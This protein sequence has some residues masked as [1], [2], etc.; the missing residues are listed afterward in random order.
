MT[1]S[2]TTTHA[3]EID[4]KLRRIR[5]HL[6]A[7]DRDGLLLTTQVNVSWVLG[8]IDHLVSRTLERSFAWVL[9][10]AG[11]FEV[12]ALENEQARLEEELRVEALG[13][14]LI[15]AP[16]WGSLDTLAASR[17]GTAHVLNDGHG[18]GEAQPQVAQR[19]RLVLTEAERERMAELGAD[20]CAAVEG[21]LLDLP[22]NFETLTERE[23]AARV[24]S[25]FESRG[26]L[27]SGVM[28]G[29]NQR[30]QRYRHPV[31]T[32]APLGRDAMVVV[33][34]ARGGLHAAL[35]RT[36]SAV[37]VGPELAARHQVACEVEATMVAGSCPGRTWTEAL[38]DGLRRYRDAG[39]P[40]EWRA[41][42]QGG[43]IGYGPREYVAYP[44]DAEIAVPEPRVQ[45]FQ[46]FAWN[47]T[48]KGTKSEDT[49]I[50]EGDIATSV[51]NS[52]A[53][54]AITVETPAG[55]LTRPA[56]LEL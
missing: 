1:I 43:P 45:S 17:V 40:D 47:P 25:G 38:E 5:E 42:T 20:T 6:A 15:S 36:I 50:V 19:L 33:V 49:F 14:E 51:T 27:T 26:V 7:H 8:G 24:V 3:G 30:R 18:P 31:V 29:G 54:P 48:V 44:G 53:W 35:S 21:A 12:L 10:T 2:E 55:P 52:D 34:G 46:A 37:S 11:A 22:S 16:W 39:Y 41:H 13:A 28:V 32:D 23:L 9:V 56:I 4:V